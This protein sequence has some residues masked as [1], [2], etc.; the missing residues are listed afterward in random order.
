MKTRWSWACFIALL[1][2]LVAE[3][4]VPPAT[5]FDS[6]THFSLVI[7]PSFALEPMQEAP[8]HIRL[9][10][11]SKPGKALP[12][13]TILAFPPETYPR[14]RTPD[15]FRELLIN[16]YRAV[17]ILDAQSSDRCPN[18]SI[19][20][21][22]FA[23]VCIEFVEGKESVLAFVELRRGLLADYV[24]TLISRRDAMQESWNDWEKLLESFSAPQRPQPRS[25]RLERNRVVLIVL[26]SSVI[27]FLIWAVRKRTITK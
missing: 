20:P 5:Y 7:P 15:R 16:E 1:V 18:R 8:D 21:K 11:R 24:L 4:E 14:A 23:G 22:V 25:S 12:R 2:A 3:A 19:T 13:V 6:R 10:L 9:L 17:G 27:V 26:L